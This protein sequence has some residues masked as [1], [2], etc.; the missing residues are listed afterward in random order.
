MCLLYC[1]IQRFSLG[2]LLLVIFSRFLF[3]FFNYLN[4]AVS[5]NL[6]YTVNKYTVNKSLT[7]VKL[8]IPN[9]FLV[10]LD[11]DFANKLVPCVS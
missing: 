1:T 7:S 6:T 3:I 4:L 9:I 8:K 10:F 11:L 2:I 5:P